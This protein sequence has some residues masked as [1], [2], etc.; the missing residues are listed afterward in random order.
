M[1]S[2]QTGNGCGLTLRCAVV[3]GRALVRGAAFLSEMARFETEILSTRHNF[4]VLEG[5]PSEWIQ[6]VH[7]RTGLRELILDMDSSESPGHGEQERHAYNEHFGCECYHSLFCFNR[8]AGV[9][10]AKL[11]PGNAHSADGQREVLEPIVARYERWKIA[12]YFRAD[13]AFAK[14]EVHEFL[15]REGFRCLSA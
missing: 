4:R 1:R 11:R 15:E 8:F 2:T 12:G 14:P 5:L 13:A 9:E 6:P 10:A 3:G 7:N